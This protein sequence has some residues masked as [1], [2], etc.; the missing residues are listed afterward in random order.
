MI[1]GSEYFE[2]IKSLRKAQERFSNKRRPDYAMKK[3]DLEKKVDAYTISLL[4]KTNSDEMTQ[5]IQLFREMRKK[6]LV[7]KINRK[8]SHIGRRT[9]AEKDVDDYVISIERGGQ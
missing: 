7:C 4:G 1:V 3:S 9:I 5:L 8:P 2:M 6:Q